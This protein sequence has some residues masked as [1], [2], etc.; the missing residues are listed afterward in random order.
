MR[1]HWWNYN[2]NFWLLCYGT[3][4]KMAMHYSSKAK[5]KTFFLFCVR[6]ILSILLISFLYFFSSL[7][8]HLC[9]SISLI[10]STLSFS[11]SFLFSKLSLFLLNFFTQILFSFFS[12]FL[13]LFSIFS[14]LCEGLFFCCVGVGVVGHRRH[15][16]VVGI[17]SHRFWVMPWVW[18]VIDFGSCHECGLPWVLFLWL[19]VDFLG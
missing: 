6:A 3:Q 5:Q 10:F 9:S 7:F 8:F 17:V 13:S 19:W 11:C 16:H 18:W 4:L 2:Q 14:M 12:N 15:G 1:L